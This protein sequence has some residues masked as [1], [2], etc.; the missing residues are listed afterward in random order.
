MSL[1]K[2]FDSFVI[3]F[4]LVQLFAV[5]LNSLVKRFFK[6]D[7]LFAEVVAL[8]GMIGLDSFFTGRQSLLV[9]LELLLRSHLFS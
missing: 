8:F 6:P 7:N 9:L 4:E 3:L 1:F 5:V 2:S